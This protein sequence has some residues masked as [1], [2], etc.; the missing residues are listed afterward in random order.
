MRSVL[1]FIFQVLFDRVIHLPV[2]WLLAAVRI[3]LI[4]FFGATEHIKCRFS[5]ESHQLTIL[6]DAKRKCGLMRTY[7]IQPQRKLLIIIILGLHSVIQS[8]DPDHNNHDK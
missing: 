6:T 7:N 8:I 1:L 2:A 5:G 4:S 3:I